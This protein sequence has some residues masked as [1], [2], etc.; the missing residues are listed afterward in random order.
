MDWKLDRKRRE[1]T[2][3]LAKKSAVRN[4]NIMDEMEREFTLIFGEGRKGEFSS[5]PYH[6]R[7]GV[8]AEAL[9]GP[10]IPAVI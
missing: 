2:Q 8:G 10:D 7:D 6:A 4:V 5:S 3:A 9:S 1:K